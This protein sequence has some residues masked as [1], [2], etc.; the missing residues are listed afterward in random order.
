MSALWKTF[1]AVP[2]CFR[3]TFYGE[4]AEHNSAHLAVSCS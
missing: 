1:S 3:A 2:R 4:Q